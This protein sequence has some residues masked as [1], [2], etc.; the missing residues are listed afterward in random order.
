MENRARICKYDHASPSDIIKEIFLLESIFLVI[1]ACKF[2]LCIN[3]RQKISLLE[4]KN[5]TRMRITMTPM[6]TTV[7][8][9]LEMMMWLM[10]N[11]RKE[12]TY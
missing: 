1:I 11:K 5:T 10:I 4:K 3:S 6:I 2:F 9:N 7:K 8:K 12:S